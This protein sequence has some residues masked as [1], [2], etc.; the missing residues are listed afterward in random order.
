MI[1]Y[2]KIAFFDAIIKVDTADCKNDRTKRFR[3]LPFLLDW[4][5]AA[6]AGLVK[7]AKHRAAACP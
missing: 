6:V 2:T 5:T 1:D 7:D 3:T 4:L